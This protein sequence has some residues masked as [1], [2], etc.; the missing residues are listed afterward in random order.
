MPSTKKNNGVIIETCSV[1]D[2][3]TKEN[4]RKVSADFPNTFHHLP[5]AATS[6]SA[7][8]STVTKKNYFSVLSVDD[9]EDDG[10]EKVESK[11]KKPKKLNYV[12][13]VRG[14]NSMG[15][16]TARATK[17]AVDVNMVGYEG[18]M[19][20]RKWGSGKITIDSGAGESVCP[21]DMVPEEPLHAR[22]N[23]GT[24]YRA[25]GGQSLV[26]K[27]E[28]CIKF[29]SGRKLGSLSFQAI[30]E[31]KKPLASAAKIANRGNVVVLDGDGCDSYIS[32]KATEQKILIYQENN[33]YV[34]DFDFMPEDVQ[35]PFQRQA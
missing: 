24:R 25:A 13:A 30:E 5:L 21:L 32:N 11:R 27:G 15:N 2:G 3:A 9:E 29:R 19:K 16:H 35:V 4:V 31:V 22:V 34:M 7:T 8:I 17:P 20:L 26:N 28:K 10:W 18:K 23:N 6:P 33:V 1:Y 12:E 14:P